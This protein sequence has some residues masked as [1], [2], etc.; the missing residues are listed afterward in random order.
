MLNTIDAFE[1]DVLSQL[2]YIRMF[3]PQKTILKSR[4]RK[5]VFSGSG[6]SF[7]AAMLAQSLSNYSVMAI[8]PL[9]IAENPKI[10]HNKHVYF[11]SI[12]GNTIANIRAAKAVKNS[13]AITKNP[14]SLLANACKS[15]I[16]LRY[17]D[18]GVFTAGSIGFL[19]SALTCISLVMPVALKNVKKAFLAAREASK[20]VTSVG[21]P[22]FLGGQFTY[23]VAMYGAA[24]MYE[25][26]GLDARY[27]RI[28][29]FSHMGLFCTKKN[30][31]V[32]ILDES[33]HAT[34][35]SK[36]LAGIG[37]DVCRPTYR[38]TNVVEKILFYIFFTQFLALGMARRRHQKE[39]HFVLQNQVR[40]AS[41]DMI[42]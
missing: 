19:A 10:A 12:S 18:S 38:T 15:T 3:V 40:N 32:I 29:Q 41:S 26:V 42:Y 2:D 25:V 33:R 16:V 22:F 20:K 31:V 5:M 7:A 36:V 27:E 1:R 17:V 37:L 28:E 23:P 13:T 4:L 6:D 35:L 21:K 34:K 8:D 11:V 14:S 30:D 24:K 39:C 9:E